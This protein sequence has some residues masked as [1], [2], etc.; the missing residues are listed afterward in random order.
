[1]MSMT[2]AEGRAYRAAIRQAVAAAGRDPE[3]AKR[4][5]GANEAK[6]ALRE[7]LGLPLQYGVNPQLHQA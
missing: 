2:I 3:Q 1:M 7:K 5:F 4:T 6:F